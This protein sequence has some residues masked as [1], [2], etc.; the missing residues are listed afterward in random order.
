M[1]VSELLLLALFTY[2][3][4]LVRTMLIIKVSRTNTNT[5]NT[6]NTNN[7]ISKLSILLQAQ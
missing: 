4:S 3:L 5:K 2:V 7:I 1:I 6:K